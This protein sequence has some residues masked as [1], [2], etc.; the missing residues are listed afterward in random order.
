[1]AI[2]EVCSTCE[3]K[4]YASEADRAAGILCEDCGGQ[5]MHGG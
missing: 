5:G 2:E 3:G 4:G 1:M